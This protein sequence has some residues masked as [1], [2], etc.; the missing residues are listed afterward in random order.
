MMDTPSTIDPPAMSMALEK[1]LDVYARELPNLL[2]EEG[3]FAVICGEQVVGTYASY[4]DAL[5]VGYEKCGLRPFLVKKIQSVEQVQYFS[6]D[7]AFPCRT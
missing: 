3:K 6:R 1:E 2:A 7:L 5:K 4:E